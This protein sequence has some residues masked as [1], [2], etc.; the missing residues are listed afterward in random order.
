MNTW[1]VSLDTSLSSHFVADFIQHLFYQDYLT[2]EKYIF[3]I[4]VVVV[5][6]DD[7]DDDDRVIVFAF[8]PN[9]E[10]ILD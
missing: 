3:I 10:S 9:E 1:D 4:V 2:K 7:D 6:V 8:I 5:V